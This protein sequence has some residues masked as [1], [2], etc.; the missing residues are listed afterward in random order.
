MQAVFILLINVKAM[1][2]TESVVRLSSAQLNTY[3]T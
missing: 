1:K 3:R 2:T